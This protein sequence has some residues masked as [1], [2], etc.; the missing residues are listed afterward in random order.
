MKIILI[1]NAELKQDEKFGSLIDEFEV[2]VRINRFR[3]ETFEECLG[4]KTDIWAMN[5]TLP[6]NRAAV[7]FNFQKEYGIRKKNK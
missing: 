4:S 3:V 7:S 2:V 1:G 5:R 6:F